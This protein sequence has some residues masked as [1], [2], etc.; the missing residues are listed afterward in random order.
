MNLD[1][2]RFDEAIAALRERVPMTDDEFAQ[3]TEDAQRRAF[4]V[5]NAANADMV[6]EVWRN[7]LRAVEEGLSF[8]DWRGSFEEDPL[9]TWTASRLDTIFRTNVQQAYSDGRWAQQTDPDVLEERP[10]WQFDGVEDD[11]QSDICSACNGVVL[12]AVDPF[13]ATHN[14]PLHFNCRSTIVSLDADQARELG[15]SRDAPAV[16]VQS[17]FG[18]APQ[19]AAEWSPDPGDYPSEIGDVLSARI[20]E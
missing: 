11:R 13:W 1:P 6:A 8:S 16:R 15:I 3:L 9:A 12:P 20:A 17:G 18:N 14:P 5:A 7:L 2:G 10:Y 19:T 4:R